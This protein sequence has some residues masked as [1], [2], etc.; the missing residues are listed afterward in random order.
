[1]A[2]K[3]GVGQI[4]LRGL[5]EALAGVL[6]IR[7]HEQHLPGQFEDVQPRAHGGDAESQRRGEIGLVQHLAVTRGQQG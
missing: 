7:R 3:A 4:D 1:M 6:E 2:G 5:D